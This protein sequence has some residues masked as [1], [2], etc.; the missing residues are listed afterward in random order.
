[1]PSAGQMIQF[2]AGLYANFAAI[3]SKDV[4]TIYFCTDTQQIF[5]GDTEYSRPVLSGTG[6]PSDG[7]AKHN[8]PRT[9]YFDTTNK[10][11]YVTL[12]DG[13]WVKITDSSIASNLTTLQNTVNNISTRL[14]TAEGEIDDLQ[15]LPATG[16][17][18]DNITSWNNKVGSVALSSGANNGTVKLTVDGVETD[19]IAVKGLGSAAYTN[20]SAYATAAQGTKADNAMPKSGGTFTGSVTLNAD[21][22]TDLQAATKQY[23]DSKTAA[24]TGAMHF[25]G[26]STTDPTGSSG[27][28]VS[29]HT[30]WAAGDVVLYGTKEYVLKTATNAA[31]N[32]I[33]LGDEGSHALKTTTITAGGGLTGGGDL[34]ANRTIS[35]AAKSSSL[36]NVDKSANT[37]VSGVAFDDY[38]HATSVETSTISGSDGITVDNGAIKH[39]NSVIAQSTESLLKVKYDAQ[40]HITGSSAV[41]ASDI[42]GLS[43]KQDAL[44]TEQLSAVNS[45]ITSSKVSS[46]DTHVG[47]ADIHVTA[48]QK[49]AWTA[50][51]NALTAGSGISLSGDT[52]DTTAKTYVVEYKSHS[53]TGDDD[54][55]TPTEVPELAAQLTTIYNAAVAG[56]TFNVVMAL[57]SDM[58]PCHVSYST[59]TQTITIIAHKQY[60]GQNGHFTYLITRS[61]KTSPNITCTRSNYYAEMDSLD[62]GSDKW[63]DAPTSI[64]VG[65]YV[66]NKLSTKQDTLVFNTAYNASTNKVATMADIQNA[67]LVWGSF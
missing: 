50:K 65:R 42:P 67:S 25:V 40:G 39:T 32:W 58:Y 13:K 51:Q 41:V 53:Q 2:K 54:I 61:A 55:W 4:N 21:P 19:N 7:A 18:Q 22:T 63:Y 30:T 64:S 24:L 62:S 36:S 17:T 27:A 46:Y 9:L 28:T 43:G 10:N 49:A 29:G 47:N 12:D 57:D 44:T 34:S 35:H 8:P 6:A 15:A 5:V 23:V 60:S 56:D 38:G 16:I 11:L 1:M 3:T 66:D 45:G 52:I 20:S 59:R 48:D 37:F 33:E 26:V 31:A 14:T